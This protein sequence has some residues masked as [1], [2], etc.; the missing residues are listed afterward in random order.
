M[1][2]LSR[3]GCLVHNFLL[4]VSQAVVHLLANDII[5]ECKYVLGLDIVFGNFIELLQYHVLSVTFQAIRYTGL[6]SG[7]SFTGGNN[8]RSSANGLKGSDGVGRFRRSHNESLEI[9]HRTNIC[10]LGQGIPE[11]QRKNGKKVHIAAGNHAI[12]EIGNF[13]VLYA[14][15]GL[16]SVFHQV[17]DIENTSCR[18]V[19]GQ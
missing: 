13:F 8:G 3:L 10:I 6:H 9:V 18:I 1:D 11:I 12:N 14:F 2:A 15:E 19:V 5:G 7:I 4:L 17:R 16:I